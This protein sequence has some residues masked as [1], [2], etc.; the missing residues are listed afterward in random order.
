ML[1]IRAFVALGCAVGFAAMLT[2]VFA[3]TRH[4]F[5]DRVAAVFHST[6]LAMES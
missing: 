5:A 3:P 6:D 4:T 1:A 2:N